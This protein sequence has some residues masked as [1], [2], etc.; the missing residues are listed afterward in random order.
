MVARSHKEHTA[1][2]CIF[3]E[4]GLGVKCGSDSSGAK[5]G[6]AT[7]SPPRRPVGTLS[8]TAVAGNHCGCFS[9][10]TVTS[11]AKASSIAIPPT[12]NAPRR[13]P[14][15]SAMVAAPT[16]PMGCAGGKSRSTWPAPAVAGRFG[17][18]RERAGQLH[19]TLYRSGYGCSETRVGSLSYDVRI[20]PLS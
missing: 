2:E 11:T 6:V 13:V 4:T 5:A 7:G 16:A 20:V 10:R 14:E 8:G 12:A 1:A 19:G 15:T 3:G 18:S 9:G 17:V